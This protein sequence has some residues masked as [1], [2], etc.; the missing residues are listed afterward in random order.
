ACTKGNETTHAA[1]EPERT[2]MSDSDLKKMVEEKINADTQLQAA[3]LDVSAD[4]DKN[5]AT[6]SGKVESEALRAKTVE[7]SKSANPGLV[8]NDKIDVKPLEKT[9]A[10]Y[11]AED[12]RA[13]VDSAKEHKE[14]VGSGMDDAWIH[15]K[16]VAKLITDRDT[17]ERKINVDVNNN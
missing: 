4:A 5:T 8:I 1:R 14:T 10:E 3:N 7:L 13:E 11:T 17:P 15:S 9:R 6:L 2:K 12:A 16:I